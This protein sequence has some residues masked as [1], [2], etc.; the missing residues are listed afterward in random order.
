MGVIVEGVSFWY[1]NVKALEDVSLRVDIGE[2]MSILGPNGAGKS[3]LIRC[4]GGILKLQRGSV[5]VNGRD[6]A[7]LKPRER[8]KL[9]GYVPQSAPGLF[10]FTVFETVLMGRR[11]HLRW[12]PNGR[13]LEV[14]SETLDLLGLKRFA[15]RHITE[16][17][18]GERQRVLL[19]QALARES[20]VL[21]LDEPTANLD[22]R[23]QLEILEIVA[24]LVRYR[25]IATIMAIHDVNLASRFSNRI[26]LLNRGRVFAAGE[27]G[28]V[29]TSENVRAVYSVEAILNSASGTPYI[30]PITPVSR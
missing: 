30:I 1:Q 24:E 27:P 3:T 12:S 18:G 8:A 4:I 28:S 15:L 26:A 29:L 7:K 19:S 11:P 22:L 5:L 14:V 6:M 2:V 16:L 21:L 17:S 20:E 10:P 13:D 9:I 23:G 25:A